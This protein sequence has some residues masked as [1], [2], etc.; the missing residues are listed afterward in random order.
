[1]IFLAF[2]WLWPELRLVGKEG[3]WASLFLGVACHKRCQVLSTF[4]VPKATSGGS[5]VQEQSTPSSWDACCTSEGLRR[6]SVG[7]QTILDASIPPSEQP[8]PGSEVTSLAMVGL[9]I[10]HVSP[11]SPAPV[12]AQ[13]SSQRGAPGS[14]WMCWD[15]GQCGLFQEATN[16]PWF[17]PG[18][19]SLGPLKRGLTE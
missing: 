13:P 1:M 9:F 2:V 10:L 19:V 14:C 11:F 15:Q 12:P 16:K 3:D 7:R 6:R 4:L 8:V 18:R 5:A 17:W